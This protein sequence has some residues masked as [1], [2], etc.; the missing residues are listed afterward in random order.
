MIQAA[1]FMQNTEPMRNGLISGIWLTKNR[2][3][4]KKAMPNTIR[5]M[6]VAMIIMCSLIN[7]LSISGWLPSFGPA[8]DLKAL[9]SATFMTILSSFP[10]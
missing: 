1:L 7:W 3:M 5:N 6:P 4:Q 10:W 9:I 2:L 8:S